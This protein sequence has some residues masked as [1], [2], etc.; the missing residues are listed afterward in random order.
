MCG[1]AARKQRQTPS[2]F[3][4]TTLFHASSVSSRAGTV[5]AMPALATRIATRPKVWTACAAKEF[6]DSVEVTSSSLTRALRPAPL[7]ASLTSPTSCGS[8]GS[9]PS[10]TSAPARANAIAVAAP[11]PDAA[12]VTRAARPFRSHTDSEHHVAA[13]GPQGLANVIGGVVRSEEDGGRRHLVRLAEPADGKLAALLVLPLVGLI[14][15]H[16]GED[17]PRRDRV[18]PHALGRHLARERLRKCENAA[19]ARA[20]VNHLVS[21]DLTELRADV[22]DVAVAALEHLR[23]HVPRTEKHCAE[24]DVHHLV[25]LL[26]RHLVQEHLREDARVVDEDLDGAELSLHAL[27]HGLDLGFLGDVR[28]HVDRAA[29]A[30]AQRGQ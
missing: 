7:T 17:R 11:M 13:V 6:T 26:G 12:P 9:Q 2:R 18:N 16:V 8:L 5:R 28:L 1:S 22:D 27:D 15:H 24:V 4:S 23:Q 19:L 20:V 3:T 21:A 25:P 10:A 29:A 30:F 14:F